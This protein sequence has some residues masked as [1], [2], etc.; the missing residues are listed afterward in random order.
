MK[1]AKKILVIDDIDDNLF[2]IRT[3]LEKSH[4]EFAILLA[5]SGL[6][7]IEIA[8]Q[9]LPETILLDIFMPGLDGFETCK[10]LKS[11]ELT[12]S[13]PVL[14][15][16]AGGDSSNIRIDGLR[17]GADAIISKPIERE[18]FVAF[19]NVML[20]MKHAEDKLKKQNQELEIFIRKQL[21]DF[22]Q[23]E[24]RFMQV[25]GYALEF[26]WEMNNMGVVIYVSPVVEEILG[27]SAE[28][29]ID[30]V[31]FLPFNKGRK[32]QP[33][34]STRNAA[35]DLRHNFRDKR[36]IFRHKN[37]KKVWMSESG[38]SLRDQSGEIIGYRG[39][40]QD[41]TE[42]VK[43][44]IDLKNSLQRIN[45]YQVR[46][47]QMNAELSI[48]EEKERRKI[49]EYLHDGLSQNLSLVNLKLTALQNSVLS[50][51]IE[52]SIIETVA[53][54][55]KAITET[56]L[57]TYD[58]SP[59]ILYELG[60]IHAISWKLGEIEN[61]YQIN[62]ILEKNA[63]P[64]NISTDKSVLLYRVISELLNNIIKHASADLVKVSVSEI[65]DKLYIS[66]MDNGTGFNFDE[67]S[68]LMVKGSFGLFSIRERLDSIHGSLTIESKSQIGTKATIEI[69]L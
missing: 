68:D 50:P 66:V 52:K 19:V 55:N 43:T 13:I 42:S 3:I 11:N 16:S 7:G 26:F 20:R 69:P 29:I 65:E 34:N 28:E 48:T 2:L 44:E 33:V 51:K 57:L 39:V 18:E 30:Q 53:L 6:Q 35:L 4:P 58:L 67:K 15:V 27:Y 60:L 31:C 22:R 21:K 36:L 25:S 14:M 23:T 59:P 32:V 37:G 45:D 54:V 46:L 64:A 56:R 49:A 10:I 9:E 24:E 40:C 17:S 5:N 38:F 8:Q 47:K 41:I 63:E 62:T 12:A 1:P 61:K